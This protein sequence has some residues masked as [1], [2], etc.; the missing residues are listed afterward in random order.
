M[1]ANVGGLDRILRFVVGAA[2]LALTASGAIGLWGLIGIVLVA[3]AA[4]RFC[5]AYRLVGLNTCP[6][7]SAP[8]TR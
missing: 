1:K 7:Q 6:L 8:D 5:P 3:T 2:L 4:F